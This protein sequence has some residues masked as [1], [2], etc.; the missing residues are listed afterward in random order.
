MAA[1]IVGFIVAV[2][3]GATLPSGAAALLGGAGPAIVAIDVKAEQIDAA[4]PQVCAALQPTTARL[5]AKLA[6]TR[7]KGLRALIG[8]AQ[9]RLARD[10]KIVCVDAAAEPNTPA[11]RVAAAAAVLAD[12]AKADGL[13]APTTKS[14]TGLCGRKA[15]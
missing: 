12:L 3:S 8:A 14:G 6:A 1:P 9:A 4:L 13:F 11:G 10:V 7:T 2:L 5:A 15:C